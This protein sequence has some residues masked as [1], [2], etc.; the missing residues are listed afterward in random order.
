MLVALQLEVFW[1]LESRENRAAVFV[2]VHLDFL[3]L[4]TPLDYHSWV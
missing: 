2:I 1:S 3:E 4:I